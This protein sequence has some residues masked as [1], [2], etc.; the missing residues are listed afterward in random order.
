MDS[1]ETASVSRVI[2]TVKA[3]KNT[4]I[5]VDFDETIFL[6]NSTSEYLNSLQPRL[7]GALVL[8]L[9]NHVQPWY[10]LPAPFKGE[11]SRD[12]LLIVTTTLLFP[13]TMLFWQKKAKK[14]GEAFGNQE[15]IKVLN[16]NNSNSIIIATLGFRLIVN[17][18]LKN[19]PLKYDRLI[20]CDFWRGIIDRHRGKLAMTLE[21]LGEKAVSNAIAIT[22]S[23]EDLP[24]LKQ[25]S[26]PLYTIWPQASYTPAMANI[27]LPFLYLEKAKRPGDKYIFKVIL[28][29]D[30]IILLLALNFVTTVPPIGKIIGL[31]LL[32]FS[33]WCIYESGYLENDLIAE[34]FEASPVLSDT[35]QNYKNLIKWW[36]PWLWGLIFAA[37]GIFGG[38]IHLDINHVIKFDTLNYSSGKI[39]FNWFCF[40]IIVRS[41]FSIYNHLNKASRVWVYLLLQIVRYFGFMLV[42]STNVIGTILLVSQTLS[43]WIPYAIYRYVGGKKDN[44]PLE[45]PRHS[46]RLSIYLF[47]LI[48]L[49]F[50]TP[51]LSM[52]RDP[53][54]LIITVFCL[55]RASTQLKRILM[56]FK[57]VWQDNSN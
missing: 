5:I 29:D 31:I 49:A 47:L 18:I 40:L 36:H 2:E 34:K 57:P 30:L 46:L 8:R 32:L 11:K 28:G 55:L 12:W 38:Q 9:L 24:L 3:A 41:L 53:Q 20:A 39:F 27:Y 14:L 51:N 45:F 44:W 56:E 19:I 7:L 50:G 10:W 37:M 15:L 22:D 43:R 54:A 16:N 26:K 6:R 1:L 25:V 17:P 21:A 13:W 48:A 42:F 23:L 4:S 33:F 35:Y 52:L